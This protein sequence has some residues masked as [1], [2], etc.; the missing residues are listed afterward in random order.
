M[1]SKATVF[2][3]DFLYV[4]T[5]LKVFIDLRVSGRT[6]FC[7]YRILST[8]AVSQIFLREMHTHISVCFP[9]RGNPWQT[10]VMTATK[11]NLMNREFTN[12]SIGEDYLE[13]QVWLKN[14]TASPKSQSQHRWKL[15][16]VPSWSSLLFLQV[17]ARVRETLLAFEGQLSFPRWNRFVFFFYLSLMSLPFSCGE[18]IPTAANGGNLTPS[19]PLPFPFASPAPSGQDLRCYLE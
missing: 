7:K 16:E 2:D 1:F 11:S 18:N 9:Q 13:E 17:A 5:F 6:H 8:A 14:S 15:A 12:R 4:A 3:V 19:I 10:K